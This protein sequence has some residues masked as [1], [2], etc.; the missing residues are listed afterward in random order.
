VNTSF[1]GH[2]RRARCIDRAPHDERRAQIRPRLQRVLRKAAEAS[3]FYRDERGEALRRG[4][5]AGTDAAFFAAFADVEPLRKTELAARFDELCTDPEI[6]LARLREVDRENAAGGATI[7]TARG[8]YNIKKTSGTSGQ[9]VYQVDTLETQRIV[10]SLVLYRTLI[11]TLTHGDGLRRIL[12]FR[13]RPRLL[14]FVHRGNRSVYQGASARGAPGWAKALLD[15]HV[16]SHEES[17]EAI[18]RKVQDLEPELIFGLP[19]RV[20]GLASSAVSVKLR[21]DPRVVFVGGETFEENLA[22]LL[23]RAWPSA[24]VVNTYGTTETKPIAAACPE[25]REL[26]VFEDIV[27]LELLDDQGAPCPP[28]TTAARVLATSLWN[29]TVPI[30]RYSLDDRIV[31]LEDAG[32]RWRTRRI[33]VRGREPAFLWTQDRRDGSW[34]PLDGRTLKE[35][36]DG[37]DE[38]AGYRV[39][40]DQP[41]SLQLTIV[42]AG[43]HPAESAERAVREGVTR[44]VADHGCA[45]SDVLDT[46][47]IRVLDQETYHRDGGKLRT[48]QSSVERPDLQR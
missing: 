2:L 44:F 3:P 31:P 34:R 47:D 1:V 41:R 21:I 26:H 14:V 28:G 10:T 40:H 18:L 43:G 15:V 30:V 38:I 35:V 42:A 5:A 13:R 33:R 23:G 45:V 7:E 24:S 22:R 25:C 17:L 8:T 11:R 46:V 9:L 37:L 16:V 29:L 19:S 36:L 20:V 39:A 12:G 27:H 6:S 32:C 48:I 4:L